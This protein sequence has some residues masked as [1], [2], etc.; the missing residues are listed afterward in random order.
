MSMFSI[1]GDWVGDIKQIN[2]SDRMMTN[3]I[4]VNPKGYHP[5]VYK[6]SLQIAKE[7]Q[8]KHVRL[9]GRPLTTAEFST[10]RIAG[11]AAIANNAEDWKL[12]Q[13]CVDTVGRLRRSCKNEIRPE[14]NWLPASP[15]RYDRV[16]GIAPGVASHLPQYGD[17]STGTSMAISPAL[18]SPCCSLTT[19]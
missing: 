12:A 17:R 19:P 14:I 18:C 9:G 1:L 15:I 6:F 16:P 10:I 7:I 3:L 11:F 4:G 13:R 5:Q 8:D 2:D